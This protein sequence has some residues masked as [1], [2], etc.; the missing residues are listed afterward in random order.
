MLHVLSKQ[1]DGALAVESIYCTENFTSALH[2]CW[3]HIA[4]AMLIY[5][6]A[7]IITRLNCIMFFIS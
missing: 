5:A 2:N 1:V 6:P 4:S 7:M 3:I